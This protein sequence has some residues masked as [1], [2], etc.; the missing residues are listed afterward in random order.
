MQFPRKKRKFSKEK[1][2]KEILKNLKKTENFKIFK[3]KRMKIS[4]KN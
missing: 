1:K 3:K 4:K 2:F